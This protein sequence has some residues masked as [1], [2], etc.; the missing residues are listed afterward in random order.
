M[1]LGGAKDLSAREWR[2]WICWWVDGWGCLVVISPV[3]SDLWRRGTGSAGEWGSI[4]GSD[5][6]KRAAYSSLIS[7]SLEEPI[8]HHPRSQPK[9]VPHPLTCTAPRHSPTSRP[10]RTSFQPALTPVPQHH[11]TPSTESQSLTH[12]RTL[13][14]VYASH[15]SQSLTTGPTA[16]Q[17]SPFLDQ[18]HTAHQS[19]TTTDPAGRGEPTR[20]L[21]Y[22]LQHTIHRRTRMYE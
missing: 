1:A 2:D 4:V 12:C 9:P 20:V 13:P 11:T 3:S 15:T 6:K 19:V 18:R 22:S 16:R 5:W 10:S 7:H 8:H 21:A 17:W 14:T